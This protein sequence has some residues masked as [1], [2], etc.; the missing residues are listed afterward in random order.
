MK[1]VLLDA[2]NIFFRGRHVASRMS[3]DEDMVGM[4]LHLTISSIQ[5]VV[6]RFGGGSDFHV[7]LCTEGKS[8]R[9]SVYSPYKANRSAKRDEMSPRE[10]NL[11]KMFYEAYDDLLNFFKEKTNV[12]VLH[13]PIAEADDLIA[14][15]I[16]LHPNDHH[17]IISSDTDFCQL[18]SNNVNIYDG[19]NDHLI[20]VDGYF[21][22]KNRPVKNKKGEV[23]EFGDPKYHLFYKAIRGDTSDNIFSAYPGVREK[24]TKKT[25]GLLECYED[26]DKKGFNWNSVMLQRWVDHEGV[27]HRVIDDYNRNMLLIDLT[28]QPDEVKMFIDDSI[29]SSLS[30][31]R[32]PNVGVHLMKF[33]AKHNLNKLSESSTSIAKWVNS[34]YNGHLVNKQGVKNEV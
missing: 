32:V 6:T 13:C 11:D 2:S 22:S 26:K 33:L 14:R 16:H 27:E 23:K 18:V 12:S 8:W 1:Y 30:K 21:D 19:I 25:I 4:A 31:E 15:M 28:A 24:S 7:V 20:T 29:K 10:V 9:K 34:C 3:S 5:S 17:Y